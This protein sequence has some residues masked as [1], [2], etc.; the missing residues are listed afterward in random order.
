MSNV[1]EIL[2][3]SIEDKSGLGGL[4]RFNAIFTGSFETADGTPDLPGISTAVNSAFPADQAAAILAAVSRKLESGRKP[5]KGHAAVLLETPEDAGRTVPQVFAKYFDVDPNNVRDIVKEAR[6]MRAAMGKSMPSQWAPHADKAIMGE[7]R[8][9]DV[10]AEIALVEKVTE[11][12]TTVEERA[13]TPDIKRTWPEKASPARPV[14]VAPRPPRVKVEPL[15]PADE[16]IRQFVYG[17]TACT[18]IDIIDF[19]RYLKDKGY[20]LQEY[21]VLEKIY[22]T[23][24]KRKKEARFAI[25]NEIEGLIGTIQAPKEPDIRRLLRRL[26]EAGL[27]F[28]EEDVRR[29]VRRA[30]LRRA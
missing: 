28:E 10:P 22:V 5:R 9:T 13:K 14:A 21:I 2:R 26:N 18:S 3:E 29:M 8:E 12:K 1:E 15:S 11:I 16:E 27:V 4:M 30:V 6:R 17:R 24:E 20:S 7:G 19:I 23:I 25:E